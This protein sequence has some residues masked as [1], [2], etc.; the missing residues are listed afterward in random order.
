MMTP[1][2]REWDAVKE[3]CDALRAKVLKVTKEAEAKQKRTSRPS[4]AFRDLESELVKFVERL[5]HVTVLDPACGSGNFRFGI[6]AGT[7]AWIAK[8]LFFAFLILLVV[9]LIFGRRGTA[10]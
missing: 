7:A 1:L 6:I 5:A 8:V 4:K 3:K 9:S 2:R 10:V